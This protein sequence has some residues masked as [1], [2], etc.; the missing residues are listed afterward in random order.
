[1]AIAELRKLQ[2]D[3]VE[4]VTK[5]EDLS[6][7]N[8]TP[9]EQTAFD[10][11]VT[12]VA[13]IDERVKTLEDE[14]A[15]DASADA[16]AAP[17]PAAA[18][19]NSA[20]LDLIK[21]STRKSAPMYGAANFVSDLGDKRATKNRSD[22][23]RG[24][25]LKGTKGFRSE[26]AKAAHEIN[27]DLNSNTINIEGIAE[28]RAQGIGSTGIGGA[29]IN[30]TFYGTLTSALK[31]YNGVRQIAKILQTSNGSNISMPCLDDTA[32]AGTLIA[33]NGSISEVAL[34]F[35]S[36]TST[37]YKF[38]SGQI[39]TS[40]EL[41]QDSLI[42]VESLVAQ[43]AGVRIGRIEESLFTTGSGSGEPQGAVTASY[44][45]VT[46]SS[47]TA[48][49]IDNVLDLFFSLD[50]AYK[51]STGC[52]FMCHSSVLSALS[53]LRGS[54]GHPVLSNN[55][56]QADGRV[57]MILGYPVIINQNMAST[58]G[59][60]AKVLLF[61]DFSSYLVRDVAGDG[62]LTIV[63]QSETYATSGQIGWVAIHRSGG[64]LLA[65]NAT[66]QNPLKHLKMAAS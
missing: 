28:D 32:N 16:A 34:T 41:L 36:K 57:P 53:K 46:A 26:F 56:N 17:A 31:D 22:A 38:S 48:I 12:Q 2:S 9:E 59:A 58:I 44:V 51:Q 33:E 15:Q 60:G 45:G 54:D 30:P 27:F 4:I 18:Q 14:M 52:A 3:R 6:K 19:Q 63:R 39:L 13:G 24:W 40:Y 10:G 23:F 64:L 50:P 49:T 25:M 35:T 37:P 21:R 5:L 43:T 42:D 11:L 1:M 29:L 62:G 61:G 55:Y 65:A 7:R 8:L 66:T 20:K 47:T